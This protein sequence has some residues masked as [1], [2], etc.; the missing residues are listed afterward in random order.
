LRRALDRGIDVHKAYV[1]DVMTRNP[2]TIRDHILAAEAVEVMQSRKIY[3]LL[4]ADE[5]G[6]LVGAISMHDM[7][8]AGVV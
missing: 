7:L 3:A 8:R 2:T 6:V 4:V 1:G 5:R